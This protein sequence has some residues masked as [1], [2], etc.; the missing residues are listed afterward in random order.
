M[1][2]VGTSALMTIVLAEPKADGCIDACRLLLYLGND[3]VNTD[4]EG[5]L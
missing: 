3:F 4:I 1:I 2:T 5:V